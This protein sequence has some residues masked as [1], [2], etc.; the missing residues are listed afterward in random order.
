[1][2]NIASNPILSEGRPVTLPLLDL[3]DFSQPTP[4]TRWIYEPWIGRDALTLLLGEGGASKT[5]LSLD[6]AIA[7]AT[8]GTWLG[9]TAQLPDP[10]LY[11]DEDGQLAESRRRVQR[12][13]CG[14]EIK[15]LAGLGH[16]SPRGLQIDNPRDYES[17]ATTALHLK[18]GLIVLDALVA[19]HGAEES[20]NSRMKVIMRGH[21]RRLMRDTGA[22]ILLLH[23]LAKPSESNWGSYLHRARGAGEIINASDVALGLSSHKGFSLL[24]MCRSRFIPQT[25]WPEPV[26]IT[27]EDSE[28]G[29][30][31]VA[32]AGSKIEDCIALIVKHSLQNLSIRETQAALEPLGHK[33]SVGTLQTAKTRLNTK[34]PEHHLTP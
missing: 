26:K 34:H 21:V 20:D 15:E 27:L 14:R 7:T 30:K 33:V 10:I 18:A 28:Q 6:L 4:P 32:H 5:W 17:I 8:S 16:V 31:I 19:L 24:E 25:E 29:T 13:S 2:L 12:L 11:I 23:H 9:L 22:G 1:L 3:T